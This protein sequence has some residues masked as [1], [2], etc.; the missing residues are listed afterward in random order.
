MWL[1]KLVVC[2]LHTESEDQSQGIKGRVTRLR[3][4]LKSELDL[5][6]DKLKGI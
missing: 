2:P 5:K 6:D 3:T 1:L 4:N